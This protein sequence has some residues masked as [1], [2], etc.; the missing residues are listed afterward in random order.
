MGAREMGNGGA[1]S[2]QRCSGVVGGWV[3]VVEEL[4]FEGQLALD[5][6]RVEWETSTLP[7]FDPRV[8]VVLDLIVGPSGQ[9]HERFE[10]EEKEGSM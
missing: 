2:E 6:W 4:P 10:I 5:I 1:V 3:V 7:P 9:L 8:P